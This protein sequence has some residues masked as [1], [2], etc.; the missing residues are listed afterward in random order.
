[1]IAQL[2]RERDK[3]RQTIERLRSERGTACEEHDQA[4]REC[5]KARQGVS[6]LRADLGATV[7]RRLEAESISAGLVMELAEVGGFFRPRVTSTIFYA[8][9]LGWSSMT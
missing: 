9:P 7:T 5:D 8:P 4:I 1:V 3:L 6:S 2:R